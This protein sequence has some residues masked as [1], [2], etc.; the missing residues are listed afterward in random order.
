MVP[1]PFHPLES[2][3]CQFIVGVFHDG[4]RLAF[5][6]NFRSL[7]SLEAMI[8]ILGGCGNHKS[9]TLPFRDP[10]ESSYCHFIGGNFNDG[11]PLE[12][13]KLIKGVVTL[14]Y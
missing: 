12:A 3:Y 8:L 9:G 6:A 1:R 10:L 5:G 11:Q 14:L 4:Q 7:K 2:I 13:K